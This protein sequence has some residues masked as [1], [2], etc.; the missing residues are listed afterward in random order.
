MRQ[1]PDEKRML[2]IKAAAE[3]YVKKQIRLVEQNPGRSQS[4]TI[5]KYNSVVQ[6][7]VEAT[8]R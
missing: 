6:E 3:D 2:E 5:E 4:V 1:K 8:I 7:V